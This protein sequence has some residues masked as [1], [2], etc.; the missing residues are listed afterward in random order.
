MAVPDTLTGP[1]GFE[2]IKLI[3]VVKRNAAH[4]WTMARKPG[5]AR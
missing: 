1:G 2:M 3:V 5:E 4:T